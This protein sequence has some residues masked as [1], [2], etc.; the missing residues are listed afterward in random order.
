MKLFIKMFFVVGIFQVGLVS[1][2][3]ADEFSTLGASAIHI[4]G[5]NV[6]VSVLA[7]LPTPSSSSVDGCSGNVVQTLI[8]SDLFLD[9]ITSNSIGQECAAVFQIP[10][11]MDLS[12]SIANG[13]SYLSGGYG[14]VNIISANGKIV[15]DQVKA[16][17][18]IVDSANDAVQITDTTADLNILGANGPLSLDHVTGRIAVDRSNSNLVGKYLTVLGGSKNPFKLTNGDV[19]LSKIKAI[20]PKTGKKVGVSFRIDTVNGSIKIRRGAVRSI[21]PTKRRGT[22]L[23]GGKKPA[24]R[25]TIKVVNGDVVVK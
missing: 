22:L 10:S 15:L 25:F 17:Q 6:D 2:G 5:G 7:G 3:F 19:K 9:I 8:G 4:S 16:I 24:A 11:N 14:A 13:D 21:S 20:H 18:A 1:L 12:L 23:R